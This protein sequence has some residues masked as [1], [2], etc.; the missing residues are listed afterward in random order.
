M[1]TEYSQVLKQRLAPLPSND[2]HSAIEQ[3]GA[4]ASKYL[5]EAIL[6][7]NARLGHGYAE[8]HPELIAAFMRTAASDYNAW[9]LGVATGHVCKQL[10]ALTDLGNELGH[11]VNA[12]GHICDSI[13][14]IS[15]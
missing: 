8:K 1:L 3:A 7:I 5:N 11:A 14:G 15:H 12:L 9:S 10:N 6:E 4:T 13:G 2:A